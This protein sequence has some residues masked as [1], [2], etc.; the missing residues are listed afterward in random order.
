LHFAASHDFLTGVWNRAAIFDFMKRELAR[1]ERDGSSVGI[2][3]VDVDHFKNVNDNYG[4]GAGDSV[5]QEITRRLSAT[6]REYDGIGR[7]GGEEFLLVMPGCNLS[8]V[9]RRADQI[10]EL[11][12]SKPVVTPSQSMNITVSMGVVATEPSSS[13]EMLLR[14][15]DAAL[16]QAKRSGRN[17]I[18]PAASFSVKEPVFGASALS[19]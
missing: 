9:G 8:S 18:Q 12:C 4:H 15:A 14:H 6:L 16:Y 13:L 19:I 11:I 1:S 5:L 17:Q 3:L 2:I 10:R 7:Y